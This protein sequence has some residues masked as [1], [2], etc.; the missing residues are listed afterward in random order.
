MILGFIGVG[1][2]GKAIIT[3]LCTGS[4]PPEKIVVYDVDEAKCRSLSERFAQVEVAPDNQTLLNRVDCVFLCVLPQIA[5]QVLLS[6][7]FREDHH[8][9][10]IIAIRPL[11]EIGEYVAPAKIVIRAVPLPGIA[12]HVGPVIFYPNN[13]AV[14]KLFASTALAIPVSS[15]DD[16]IVLS[17][18]T[19]LIAPYYELVT[20]L[21]NWA[22][23]AGVDE[24]IAGQYNLAMFDALNCLARGKETRLDELVA[25]VAT[26]GGLNYQALRDLKKK[27]AFDP[28]LEVLDDLLKRLGLEAPPR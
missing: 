11:K 27:K 13:D 5:P 6:L 3:G 21:T 9:V 28:F 17:A 26:H 4:K 22:V 20:N 1:S 8:V 24:T 2:I 12:H 18:I 14:A 25:E 15:E 10:T 16:L 7:N 23:S 19:G